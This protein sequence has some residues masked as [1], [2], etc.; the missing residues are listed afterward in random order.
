[1]KTFVVIATYNEKENIKQLLVDILALNIAGLEILVVDDNS[2]DGTAQIVQENFQHSSV[3]LIVREGERGYGSAHMAGFQEALLHQADIIISMDAD[4][5]HQ[6]KVIPEMINQIQ[7]G[8]DVII[9]SR[10]V[11]GGQIVGWGATRKLASNTAMVLTR[12]ILGIKTKD[13]TTGFRAYKAQIMPQLELFTVKS[14][15]YSFLEELIYRCEKKQLKIKEIPII[16]NDRQFGK[17]KFSLKEIIKFFITIF[18]L[19]LGIK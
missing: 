18:K 7:Q 2:P 12:F 11:P 6:P 19:R 14:N 10:R 9:G 5:S 1:M 16:F 17:S 3:H 15:G 8:Y 13:V 4:F